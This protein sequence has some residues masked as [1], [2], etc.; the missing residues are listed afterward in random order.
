[1][2]PA[3][4]RLKA[5]EPLE[6]VIAALR[7]TGA[8][9]LEDLLDAETLSCLNAELD[10]ELER[11][12]PDR[13]F[14]NPALA[15]F[16]G[17]CTRH[18]TAVASKSR[19]FATRILCHP[20]Y[21]GVCDAILGPSCARYQLNLAHVLDRGPGAEAQFLH[22]DELVWVHVPRP[23]PELQIASMIALVDFTKENGATQLVPGSHRWPHMLVTCRSRLPSLS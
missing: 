5:S 20:T 13:E 12:Q 2:P 11:A 6:D 15:W 10:L 1:M 18:V 4:P 7:E 19:T 21:L 16:F 14:L 3:V 17:K 23:H 8:L 9:I 22:R